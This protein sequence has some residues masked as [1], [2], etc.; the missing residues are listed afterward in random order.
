VADLAVLEVAAR[1][2]DLKPAQIVDGG[3]GARDRISHRIVAACMGRPDELDNLVNVVG[4]A[5]PPWAGAYRRT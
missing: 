1:F 3:A 2:G 4:H 5:I